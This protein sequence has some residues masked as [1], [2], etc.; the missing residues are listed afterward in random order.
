MKKFIEI[1]HGARRIEWL[2]LGIMFAALLLYMS[3]AEYG[4]GH[5]TDLERR[6]QDI[7]SHINGAGNVE[8]M[9]VQNE[10]AE[11]EGVL[12]VA[13]GGRN[14][15]TCLRIQQAVHTLLGIEITKIDVVQHGG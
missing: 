12:I 6:L 15:E 8:V 4:T 13:D 1:L 2:L 11:P 3:G 7:L 14:I 10:S 9:V 5:G